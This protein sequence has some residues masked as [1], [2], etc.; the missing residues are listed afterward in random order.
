MRNILLITLS[1]IL[2][3]LAASVMA[4]EPIFYASFD[5][6]PNADISAGNGE[7]VVTGNPKYEAAKVN[8]GIVLIGSE[9]LAFETEN[10]VN[11]EIGTV[12][13]WVRLSK[14]SNMLNSQ[15]EFFSMYIDNDNR[16]RFHLDNND[17]GIHWFYKIGG[18]SG[19]AQKG[20]I[21]W[22]EG[23]WHHLIATWKRDDPLILYLDDEKIVGANSKVLDPLPATFQVGSY[24]GASSFL[25]GT[26]DEFYI[27]DEYDVT[28]EPGSEFVESSGKLATS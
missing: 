16:M 12:M 22:K 9:H 14:D 10:N 3:I 17:H 23:D 28:E 27:F 24:H 18:Q 4:A 19:I 8:D 20:E 13:L 26:I 6:G 1:L 15:E 21:D 11:A 25:Q 2:P 5:E 7:A